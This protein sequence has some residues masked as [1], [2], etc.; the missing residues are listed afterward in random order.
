MNETVGAVHC[1]HPV[2]VERS[3]KYNAFIVIVLETTKLKKHCP[4]HM[5][6]ILSHQENLERF[7]TSDISFTILLDNMSYRRSNN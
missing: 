6:G 3:I 4:I 1:L 5:K 7:I 2:R